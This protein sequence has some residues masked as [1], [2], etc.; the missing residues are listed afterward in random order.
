[1][2]SLRVL[3]VDDEPLARRGLHALCR[4]FRDVEIVAE[5]SDGRSAIKY[6]RQ[7]LVD[8]VFL[9]VQMQGTTGFDVIHEIGVTRMPLIVFVT[10]HD[11]YALSAFDVQAVDYLTKPVREERFGRALRRARAI[12]ERSHQ[13]V[14]A[15]AAADATASSETTPV[16]RIVIRAGHRTLALDPADVDWI[17][18]DDCY[19]TVHA[20]GRRYVVIESL[21]S[22]ERKLA[23]WTFVRAHRSALVNAA[24]IREVRLDVRPPRVLLVDGT[25]VRVSRRQRPAVMAAVRRLADVGESEQ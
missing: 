24:R 12:L 8:L 21:R 25:R 15:L 1:M 5:L 17:S 4:R 11:E 23:R 22:F 16:N 7:G 6:L 20:N 10:A 13:P 2:T 9:D 14:P 19:A 18:A 3:I